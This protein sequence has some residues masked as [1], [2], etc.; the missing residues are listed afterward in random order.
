MNYEYLYRVHPDVGI[1]PFIQEMANVGWEMVSMT[2]KPNSKEGN[3]ALV[4]KMPIEE[5]PKQFGTLFINQ[6]VAAYFGLD[7]L[8][9]KA[10]GKDKDKAQPRQV[11]Q[12]VMFKFG[13]S[14]DTIGKFYNQDHSNISHSI[15]NV[16]LM[17]AKSIYLAA[18][19][20]DIIKILK[21]PGPIILKT[22]ENND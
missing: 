10:P 5:D 19:V 7:P 12:Y 22:D 13:H 6:Y 8:W 2:F 15:K 16:P 3:M 9:M 21:S 14:N 18:C 20:R 11:A 17:M 1:N 4:F